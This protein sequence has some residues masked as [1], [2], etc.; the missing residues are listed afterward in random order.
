LAISEVFAT[1]LGRQIFWSGQA[2]SSPSVPFD[3]PGEFEFKQDHLHHC[4]GKQR[5]AHQFINGD[6][7]G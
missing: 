1:F 3:P 2:H 7:R 4:R 5:L 6:W